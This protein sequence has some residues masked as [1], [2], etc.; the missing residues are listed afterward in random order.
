MVNGERRRQSVFTSMTAQKARCPSGKMAGEK[1]GILYVAELREIWGK[2]SQRQLRRK[3]HLANAIIIIF[4]QIFYWLYYLPSWVLLPSS[5]PFPQSPPP[6]P[7]PPLSRLFRFPP[8]SRVATLCWAREWHFVIVAIMA[9]CREVLH[10]EVTARTWKK[11]EKKKET[12]WNGH[13]L[14]LI[15]CSFPW[16]SRKQE[17]I[18]KW[19]GFLVEEYKLSLIDVCVG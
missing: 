18:C 4:H 12:Q 15:C 9:A 16:T 10:E 14:L 19:C 2:R 7:P 13:H 11:D 1:W 8:L 3:E 17:L 5:S 6:P